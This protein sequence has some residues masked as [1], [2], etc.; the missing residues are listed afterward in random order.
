MMNGELRQVEIGVEGMTCASCSG[1][2]ERA[3]LELPGV[4][5]ASVNLST[6]RASV[7]YDATTT[8]P[9]ALADIIARTGYTPVVAENQLT[10]EGMTCA[11][12][13]RH[14]ETA[15]QGLPGVIEATVNLATERA[16]VRYFPASAGLDAFVEAVVE[17]G[18]GARPVEGGPEDEA[19]RKRASLSAMRKDVILAV[20]F[21][22][23]ILFL[24][25][26]PAFLPTLRNGLA[27]MAPFNN[28]W[29]W[30]QALLASIV[31]FGPGRRFFRPG[32]IAYRQLSPD[33]N[34][35][36]ATGTGAAW[37]F[38][39]LVLVAPELFP[40][41]AREVYFDSAAV[42]IAAVLFGKYLE[43]LAKGRTSAAIR[44][45]L[46]LQAKEAHVLRSGTE[47]TIPISAVVKGDQVVVRPGERIPVDGVVRA[48]ASHVDAA[49][50]TGEPLPVARREGDTVVGGTINQEGRLVI[51]A[52]SVG[53]DT[54]LAQIIRLVEHAQTGKLPIQGLA[55]RVVRVFT[56]TVLA[57]ALLSFG[58]WLV[59][60]PPPAITMALLSAVAVLVVACPCA[61]GLATP[62]AIM[63]GTGRSAELGVLFRK[64][65][66]LEAL[67]HVDTILLDKTGTLTKG[68]PA[69]TDWLGQ[70]RQAL[71]RVAAA[72]EAASEHPLARAVVEAAQ[73]ESIVLPEIEGF[74]AIPGYGV[75]AMVEGRTVRIGARR[76][77]EREGLAPASLGEAA[78]A[79][80]AEGKTV[81][82]VAQEDKVIGVLAIADP[83]KPDARELVSELRSMGLTV[84][85]VTGDARS[86]AAAV[87]ARLGIQDFHAEVLP[88]GKAAVV[89]Q[90]QQQG[91][92][93]VFVGDG[94]ND[95]PALAQADVG[96]A[97]ASGTDIAIEAGEVTL[98]RGELAGVVTAIRAARKTM[99]TIRGNLFW[100]FFYNILL[101]PI[102]AGAAAPWGVQLN[103][104]LA[105][106]AMGL[107]S[108]FV[109]T[110]SLRLRAIRPWLPS[111]QA[112]E[113]AAGGFADVPHL[114][115][116]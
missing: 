88:D 40:A 31:M 45:L 41:A 54:V 51:E 89:Q 96:V 92:K 44:K 87:S 19:V 105:G 72:V 102:A 60:G 25:M 2:V 49:M 63:V 91:H 38:S 62:A 111:A 66:A 65:D 101:I 75:K 68:S 39:L 34:S 82:F 76:F 23:P 64:G 13:V 33:M 90:V 3:L 46:G 80:E 12:C 20:G 10:V 69:L 29:E 17:A 81:V 48:G 93:V 30:V 103:P 77:L 79:L 83:I 114:A 71:L 100:A 94:I 57:I 99:S 27:A 32:L 7:Q 14:V 43:E 84:T 26:G 35:L 78:S 115:H 116:N 52:T 98:A 37:L 97:L 53:K 67:A 47:E 22:L 70:D 74:E 18:Y 73:Q 5:A 104:M 6:E 112:K 9:Q 24:S 11:S 42:V 1:R 107:S 16:A 50:L 8:T 28:F 109:L 4:A 55:D 61:M 21:A 108:V 59:I 85:M 58:L 86:T 36:V 113:G 106:V 95:A 110:N 56:P 15:L